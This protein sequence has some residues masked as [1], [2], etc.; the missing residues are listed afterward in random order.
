MAQG[1]GCRLHILRAHTLLSSSSSQP[2][3][4]RPVRHP[5]VRG[6]LGASAEKEL[7]TRWGDLAAANDLD[8]ELRAVHTKPAAALT[9]ASRTAAALVVGARGVGEALLLDSVA[10]RVVEQ[11]SCP[12]VVVRGR[13][14]TCSLRCASGSSCSTMALPPGSRLAGTTFRMTCGRPGC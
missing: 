8:V 3:S 14:P 5:P 11:A 4:R 9:E 6:G 10:D 2:A 12:V 7:A 13:P 1:R